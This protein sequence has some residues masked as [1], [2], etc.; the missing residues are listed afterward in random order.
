ML[1][2]STRESYYLHQYRVLVFLLFKPLTS[3]KFNKGE[4]FVHIQKMSQFSAE[5]G[6]RS[7]KIRQGLK[8]LERLNIIH[9]LK[10][11]YNQAT[12]FLEKT[13]I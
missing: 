3:V 10:F 7:Y 8:E 11:A 12:F 9:D 4:R 13:R 2:E 1:A 6:Y 5:V